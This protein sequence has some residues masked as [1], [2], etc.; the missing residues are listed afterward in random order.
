MT[1]HSVPAVGGERDEGSDETCS[2]R[3]EE[4]SGLETDWESQCWESI[5]EGS[6]D[7]DSSHA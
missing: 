7:P 6:E 3:P 4:S 5:E 1:R 2:A